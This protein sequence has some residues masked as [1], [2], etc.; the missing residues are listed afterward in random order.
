MFSNNTNFHLFV[1]FVSMIN[2]FLI[3]RETRDKKNKWI[4]ILQYM[5]LPFV[6]YVFSHLLTKT[7]MFDVLK[8]TDNLASDFSLFASSIGLSD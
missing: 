2:F 6:L 3:R 4:I 7:K 5:Y 8:K 1:I